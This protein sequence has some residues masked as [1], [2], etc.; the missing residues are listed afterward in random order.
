[1][2]VE[3]EFPVFPNNVNNKCPAIMLADNRT[4]SVPGRIILLIVSI[5]TIKGINTGGVPCGTKWAN[6]CFV[7]L[8]QPKNIKLNQRGRA[9]DRVNVMWL[10]LVKIYGNKPKKLL[11][12]MNVNSEINI[13]VVPLYLWIPNRVLNSLCRVI[14]ILFQ[15]IFNREGKNQNII[16]KNRIPKKELNQFRDKLKIFV[17]GS[18]IENRFIIIFKLKRRY[19]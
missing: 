4:A 11:K 18:K 3:R 5:K 17:E 19:Y 7:L 16:G 13:N 10:V 15:K 2:N 14:K 8:I 12:R 9:N 1:M 6:I